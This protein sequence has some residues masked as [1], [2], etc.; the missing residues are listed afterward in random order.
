MEINGGERLINT[1]R[2][3]IFAIDQNCRSTKINSLGIV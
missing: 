1:A 2:Y 3:K